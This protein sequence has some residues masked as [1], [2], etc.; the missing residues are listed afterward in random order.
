MRAPDSV[1]LSLGWLPLHPTAFPTFFQA[2]IWKGFPGKAS[3][4]VST[5]HTIKYNRAAALCSPR[6]ERDGKNV[7]K[8]TFMGRVFW[9]L[10]RH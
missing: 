10:N 8:I 2:S 9:E 6:W 4:A 5:K 1:G 3:A 7:A